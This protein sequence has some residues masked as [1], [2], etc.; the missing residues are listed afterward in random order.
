MHRRI[1]QS[2]RASMQH[3]KDKT[4]IVDAFT[5]VLKKRRRSRKNSSDV[6]VK[7]SP[8]ISS[9]E[10]YEVYRKYIYNFDLSR[11]LLERYEQVESGRFFEFCQVRDSQCFK[12]SFVPFLTDLGRKDDRESSPRFTGLFN[13]AYT[14]TSSLHTFVER[15]HSEYSR[16][17]FNSPGPRSSSLT[18][19]LNL[20]GHQHHQA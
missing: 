9:C 2:L 6:E 13:Y 8:R 12:W 20:R 5:D 11:L 10:L 15:Y 18:H 14:E 19:Q 1:L 16:I 17:A 4:S 7:V 3:W